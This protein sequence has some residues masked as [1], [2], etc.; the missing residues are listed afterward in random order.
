MIY[1]DEEILKEVKAAWEKCKTGK[2]ETH[3]DKA[4]LIEVYNKIYKTNY[5]TTT[6]CGSCL[7]SV[8]VGIKQIIDGKV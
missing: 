4:R 6:N 1:K 8:Y 2:C 5:K 7:R 3:E